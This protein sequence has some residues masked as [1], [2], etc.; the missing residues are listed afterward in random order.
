MRPPAACRPQ[1]HVI[2]G[3]DKGKQGIVQEVVRKKNSVVV[4]GLNLVRP[5]R[6]SALELTFSCVVGQCRKRVKSTPNRKGGIVLK[7]APIHYSNVN[8]VDPVSG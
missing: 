4:E 3:R 8:L 5:R 1:V 7:P 2:S 6:L